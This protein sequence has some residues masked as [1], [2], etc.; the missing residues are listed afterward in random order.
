MSVP[1]LVC[2]P[3]SRLWLLTMNVLTRHDRLQAL[4]WLFLHTVGHVDHSRRHSRTSAV[5]ARSIVL[6]R[7]PRHLGIDIEGARRH[8]A[9]TAS[10]C[11]NTEQRGIHLFYLTRHLDRL[12]ALS[13]VDVLHN[14]STRTTL[15]K[16]HKKKL[17]E[18][19][20]LGKGEASGMVKKQT[21]MNDTNHTDSGSRSSGPR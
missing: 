5:P 13:Q 20:T 17:P 7:T 12:T 19:A 15:F 10:V 3:G 6:T 14:K 11:S 21:S 18:I 1:A 2:V 16:L 8:E 9:T 4:T